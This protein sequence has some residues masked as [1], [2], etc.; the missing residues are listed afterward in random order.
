M[1][2]MTGSVPVVAAERDQTSA[3]TPA[4]ADAIPSRVD[5]P[6]SWNVRATVV[7]EGNRTE[8]IVADAQVLDVET[9]LATPGK[10]QSEL[11]EH[12]PPVVD[13]DAV[14]FPGDG[15]REGITE[16]QPIGKRAERVQPDVGHH[17]RAAGFHLHVSRAVT[18]HLGSAL[19]CGE[20]G[21]STTTVSPTGRAFPRT[22]SGQLKWRREELGLVASE[23]DKYPAP[24][25]TSAKPFPRSAMHDA[26]ED[27]TPTD[28]PYP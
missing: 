11:D 6:I 10:R 3:R 5:A 15:S 4:I 13:R 24:P 12:L 21:V 23:P 22:R 2:K 9:A 25:P 7:S 1:S 19:L 17:P 18:V 26:L 8:E 27:S 16:P 14:P 28:R 20:S